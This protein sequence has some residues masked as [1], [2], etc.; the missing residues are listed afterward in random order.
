VDIRL[1]VYA[2]WAGGSLLVWG[3][4]FAEDI[5]DYRRMRRLTKRE[6][7]ASSAA[8]ELLSDLALLL[9][10][11]ASFI[12]IVTLVIGQDV[13]GLRGFALAIALGGFFGAGV[14][15]VTFRGPRL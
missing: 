3:R 5:S 14:F 15:K 2:L 8:K 13:P 9:V 12:S 11:V 7:R 4:V 1:I 10:A 6:R